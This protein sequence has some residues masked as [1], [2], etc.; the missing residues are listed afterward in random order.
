[1][2]CLLVAALIREPIPRTHDEFSYRLMGET[3]AQGRVA[4][5]TP[6]APEFFDTFHVLARPVY[7]SK[8]FPGQGVFLALGQNLTGHPAVGIWLSSALACA[9]ITWMLQAWVGWQWGLLGGLLIV[10]QYGV[11]SYWSQTFW[12]GMVPALGGA[13]A[14]G[15]IRRLWDRVT[16]R[17]SLWLGLGLLIL[18][19]SRPLE[20]FLTVLPFGILL[21][22]HHFW[23]NRRAPSTPR[24]KLLLALLPCILVLGCG[25][26]ALGAYNR[27]ITGSAFTTPYALNEQQY[28]ESPPFI[29]LP[30]R[31][32][33]TYS[34]PV[35]QFY[36]EINEMRPYLTQ[37]VP[38]WFVTM[39]ARKLATWWDFYVGFVLSIP[40]V[41]PGLL[42]KGKIRWIQ[43]AVLVALITLSFF[44][45]LEAVLACGLIEAFVIAQVIILWHVFDDKWSRLAIVTCGL[46]EVV[47]LF[48]K[49]EFPH[50]FAPAACLI[51]YLEVEGLRKIWSWNTETIAQTERPLSRGEKRRL[52]RENG[53]R[54]SGFN[55]RWVVIATPIAC[56]LLLVWNIEQRLDGTLYDPHGKIRQALILDDWS[57]DRANLEKWLEQQTSPQLVFVRYWPNHN[58]NFEWVYN[59]PDIMHSHVMWARDLG[60]E[61]NKLLL[62]LVP[63]R[64]V[65]LVEGDRRHPQLIPYEEADN[66]PLSPNPGRQGNT[67][68]EVEQQ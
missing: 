58:I 10:I 18:V 41:L 4:N 34:S 37:R 33:L 62:N 36:Y 27:A 11:F 66:K 30:Q 54:K 21:L 28:Q 8:Y 42:Q 51:W 32:K 50:Y 14:L 13:L 25:A 31:P 65:W 35:V 2:G 59:H 48:A 60:A 55:L 46:V 53:R 19:S 15:A 61:H 12:G 49:W 45:S 24:P 57:V 68:Q 23:R 43:A 64:K 22:H 63:D 5:P 17:N 44:L 1:L 38:K 16:W 52:A 29:F 7:A 3:F 67:Q 6:P 47:L 26:F 9:A 56:V 40:L 20:G 39:A